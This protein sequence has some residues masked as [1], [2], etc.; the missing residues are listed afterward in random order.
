MPIHT[1]FEWCD[2]LLRDRITLLVVMPSGVNEKYSLAVIGG[3][4][5]LEISVTWPQMMVDSDLLHEPFKKMMEIKKGGA[6]LDGSFADYLAR[7][8]HYKL[9][10][11][12][13]ERKIDRFESK[14]TIVLPKTVHAHQI[15]TNAFGRKDGTRI[16]Y[17]NLL[18]ECT[19]S[20]KQKGTDYFII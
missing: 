5:R 4:T 3:G 6:G 12:G 13:L 7:M 11:N 19:D 15:E 18:C 8:Q 20:N 2:S 16:L 14:S 9:H 10:I 17:I 1:V